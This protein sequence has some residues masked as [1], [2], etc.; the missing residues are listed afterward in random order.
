MYSLSQRDQKIK[1]LGVA[2]LGGWAIDE[3]RF[4][5]Q[6][7]DGFLTGYQIDTQKHL[8]WLKASHKLSMPVKVFKNAVLYGFYDG[9]VWLIDKAEGRVLWQKQ[10]VRLSTR[11]AVLWKDTLFIVTAN[12]VV[13]AI[14]FKDGSVLWLKDFQM[15]GEYLRLSNLAAPIIVD[16][17]LLCSLGNGEIFALDPKDGKVRWSSRLTGGSDL[18]KGVIGQLA[19]NS[20]SLL[21]SR[22]NGL[23]AALDLS[24]GQVLWEKQHPE[25]SVSFYRDGV[26]YLGMNNGMIRA[27]RHQD[28]KTLWEKNTLG[29]TVG[30]AFHK[31]NLIRVSSR[32]FITLHDIDN[33]G[34][35][36]LHKQLMADI[37]RPPVVIADSL[38]VMT[39]HKVIYKWQVSY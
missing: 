34:R 26:F 13:Y 19:Y 27:L 3:G 8:W 22:H 28:G 31:K 10:L 38:Y 30:F 32:G 1:P 33:N 20:K 29:A 24:N 6:G 9:H 23:V 15:Q 18:F 36:L 14:S 17:R 11:S 21:L 39:S 35:L 25:I 12:A 16:E 7:E 4:Y 2:D 37:H 5:G